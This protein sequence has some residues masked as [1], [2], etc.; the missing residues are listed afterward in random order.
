MASE[1]G[2]A[3][4]LNLDDCQDRW[5]G[6]AFH[7]TPD[8]GI[9]ITNKAGGPYNDAMMQHVR[10]EYD[11]R[12][13]KSSER[14]EKTTENRHVQR[15]SVISPALFCNYLYELREKPWITAPPS[16]PY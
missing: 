3:N 6:V 1:S 2:G 9:P 11:Y 15:C 14:V 8:M 5:E 13:D 10:P 16:S 12:I 7:D 4:V